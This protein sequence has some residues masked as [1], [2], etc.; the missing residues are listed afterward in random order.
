MLKAIFNVLKFSYFVP[1]FN[2]LN[3]YLFRVCMSV[4][5]YSI[6]FLVVLYISTVCVCVVCVRTFVFIGSIAF[7]CV[8]VVDFLK[9]L[10]NEHVF[11]KA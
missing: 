6:F 5:V 11:R 10:E 9:L 3:L 7:V 1:V 4:C 8:F 2:M